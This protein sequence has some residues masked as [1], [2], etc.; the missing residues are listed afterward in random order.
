M[1]IEIIKLRL[2]K[3]INSLSV[4]KCVKKNKLHLRVR[5]PFNLIKKEQCITRNL[6]G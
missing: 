6:L 4:V 1:L 5:P 3:D 2:K